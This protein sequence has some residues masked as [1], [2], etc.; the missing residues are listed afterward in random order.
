MQLGLAKAGGFQPSRHRETCVTSFDGFPKGPKDP[1][2]SVPLIAGSSD[3]GSSGEYMGV[4]E[5]K[6]P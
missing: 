6:G 5:N 3:L 4:S 2:I 1:S